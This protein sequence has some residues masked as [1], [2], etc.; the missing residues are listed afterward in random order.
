MDIG[1]FKKDGDTYTGSIRTATLHH[2]DEVTIVPRQ[3]EAKSDRAPDFVI[4][5]E[6]AEIGISWKQK[7]KAGTGYISVLI[8]DPSFP[9]PAHARL[10]ERQGGE[11][12]FAL[13]WTRDATGPQEAA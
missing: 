5:A 3:Y 6:G 11:H 4:K 12:P 13:V 9:A 2:L 7:S 10:F 1:Y 8:D